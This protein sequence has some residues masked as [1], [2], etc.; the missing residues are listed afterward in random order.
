VSYLVRKSKKESTDSTFLKK[1][2]DSIAVHIGKFVD[3]LSGKDLID[4]LLYGTAAYY[5]YKA[6]GDK[7]HGAAVGAVSLKLASSNNT[8]AGV[9]GVSGLVLI[10]LGCSLPS[11]ILE[12]SYESMQISLKTGMPGYYIDPFTQAMKEYVA[13]KQAEEEEKQAQTEPTTS[14]LQTIEERKAWLLEHYGYRSPY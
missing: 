3:R 5:G 12:Q 7:P 11:D 10:G 14:D 8:A 9:A 13:E 2:I 6:F 4:L 1:P